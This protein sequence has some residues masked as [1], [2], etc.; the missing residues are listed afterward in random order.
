[1]FDLGFPTWYT[2]ATKIT[3]VFSGAAFIT[4]DQAGQTRTP[5]SAVGKSLAV[6]GAGTVQ[7][8]TPAPPLRSRRQWEGFRSPESVGRAVT[9]NRPVTPRIKDE[10]ALRPG[11]L[12]I[13]RE[14]TGR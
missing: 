4:P 10:K 1:M 8:V 13:G 3:R 12:V 2:T 9:R 6:A 7:Q 5:D 11:W 14:P